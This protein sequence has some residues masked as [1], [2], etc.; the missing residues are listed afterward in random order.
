[1]SEQ[2]VIKLENLTVFSGKKP[3]VEEVNLEVNKGEFVY[4]TGRVGS[5]KTSLLK[6]LY[7]ALP[8]TQGKAQVAGFD[9]ENISQKQIPFLRRNLGIVFQDFQLLTDRSVH[10]NLRLVLKATGKNNKLEIQRSINH[11][12]SRVGLLDKEHQMPHRLSGGE[13]QRIVIARAMLNNPQV[14]L[15]DEP[16]GNLDPETSEMIM[17]IFEQIQVGGTAI[18]MATHNYN[19]VRKYGGKAF[20]LENK[21]LFEI[22]PQTL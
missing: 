22:N 10:E 17:Q 15:A 11:V 18:V 20:R 21:R 13:Q 6:T 16:T 14:I 8:L 19:L 9:L 3:I 4:L 2:N 1:M 12:L 5:G 7:A